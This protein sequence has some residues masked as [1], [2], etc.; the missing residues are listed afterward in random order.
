M[1]LR[2]EYEPSP[3]KPVR[4]QVEEYERSGGTRRTTHDGGPVIIVTSV[5]SK[6]GKLR[7]NPVMRVEHDGRYAVVGSKRGAPR[8][9]SWYRN[10]VEHPLVEL[11]DG[12][13]K[14]DFIARQLHGDERELWWRRAVETWPAYAEYQGKTERELPVFL[15]EPVG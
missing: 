15:L 10:L 9:P 4:E 3:V 2:G 7:K 12:P 11:Q 1:P 5:G 13:S 6:S 14:G 8:H